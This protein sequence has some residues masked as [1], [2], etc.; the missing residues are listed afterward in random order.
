MRIGIST[1]LFDLDGA[2]LIRVTPQTIPSL[3]SGSRRVS[4]TATLDGGALLY[5]TGYA[6]ADRRHTI[7]AAEHDVRATAAWF[8]M[9][10]KTY[11]LIQVV[12]DEGVF[13]AAPSKW[14][15]INDIPTLDLLF[16]EQ[17]A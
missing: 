8:A 17:L 14:S 2:R 11:N 7:E 1:P 15:M 4:S 12:T 5:D 9:L 3:F 6:V 13:L 10:V 16:A